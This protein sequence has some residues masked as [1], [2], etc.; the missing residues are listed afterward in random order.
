MFRAS[1]LELVKGPRLLTATGALAREH[2]R[3]PVSRQPPRIEHTAAQDTGG[4]RAHARL[5]HIDD[6]TAMTFTDDEARAEAFFGKA[7]GEAGASTT[8]LLAAIG[9]SLGLFWALHAGG[10]ATPAELAGRAGI[11]ERY[12]REWL[13]AMTAASYLG[14]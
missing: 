5:A 4:H 13:A 6:G 9:D 10:P 7:L 8:V 3:A 1:P 11:D 2:R 14:A 12:A